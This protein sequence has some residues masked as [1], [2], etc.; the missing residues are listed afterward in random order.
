MNLSDFITVWQHYPSILEGFVNTLVFIL[1]AGSVSLLLGILLTPLLMSNRVFIGRSASFYCECMRCTPFLLLV[2]LIYFGLPSG[3]IQLS[4]W[5]SGIVALIIYN[6]AYMAIILKG[7]W[8]DLPHDTIEAGR[9]FGFHGFGLLRRIIMPP[10][11]L[12][13]T[14]MIGNQM[15]QIVKDS[16][17]LGI[18]AVTELTAAINAIQSTYFIPFASFLSAVLMYWVICLAIELLTNLFTRYAEV[19]RA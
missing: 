2:Y 19:R 4:N 17:F 12:R 10:V 6:T 11:L 1:I 14:P 8:K 16:A 13:A 7:A 18:I 9:A 5:V 15:I 3:G